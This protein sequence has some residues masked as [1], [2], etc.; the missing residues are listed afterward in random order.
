MLDAL[1]ACGAN[2]DDPAFQKALVFVSRCQ[3]LES[4]YNTTQFAAKINDGGF[5]YTCTV[6]KQD[7]SRESAEGG[8]RSY[9][10]MTYSGLK[11]MIYAGLT[12]DDP[13][14]KAASRW[15]RKNY[16]V[17]SNPGMGDA[18][19]FYYY[20]TFAKALDAMGLDEIEDAKGVKHDWRRELTE[21]LAKRQKDDGSWVNK[22]THWMEGDPNLATSFALLALTYCR[23][24]E[25]K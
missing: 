7:E 4:E 22:N 6:G 11:S 5:Y 18:G 2:P 3:N 19:L 8:L 14:V 25:R 12:K 17:A 23:P 16:G 13:R 9:G 21:E 1:K 20:H 15:I 24:T 10:S